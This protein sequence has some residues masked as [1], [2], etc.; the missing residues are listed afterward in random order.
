MIARQKCF[1]NPR[2]FLRTLFY[3]SGRFFLRIW[4]VFVFGGAGL[5]RFSRAFL[6][7]YKVLIRAARRPSIGA[8]ER[9]RVPWDAAYPWGL[10]GAWNVA[11]FGLFQNP[12]ITLYSFLHL[13]QKQG[14]W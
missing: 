7:R 9:A 14:A 12:S 11:V 5:G 8:L 4:R 10:L 6:S 13:H 3:Y 2:K 1:Q